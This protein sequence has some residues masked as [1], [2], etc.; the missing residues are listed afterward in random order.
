MITVSSVVFIA[1]VVTAVFGLAAAIIGLVAAVI[2]FVAALFKA[3]YWGVK[4]YKE[5]NSQA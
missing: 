3:F 1:G 5:V 4:L 2:G